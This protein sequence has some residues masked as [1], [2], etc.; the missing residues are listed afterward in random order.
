ML[1]CIGAAG[2]CIGEC[3]GAIAGLVLDGAQSRGEKRAAC[4]TRTGG[5]CGEHDRAFV[6]APELREELHAS[7][8]R[9]RRLLARL[10]SSIAVQPRAA[11]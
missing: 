1:E 8:S 5:Q 9:R 10:R 2:L 3:I 4:A 7:R 11:S 6:D